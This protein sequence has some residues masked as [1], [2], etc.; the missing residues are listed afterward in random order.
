MHRASCFLGVAKG[1]A[2]CLNGVYTQTTLYLQN[3]TLVFCALHG[4][5]YNKNPRCSKPANFP[6]QIFSPTLKP[7][8]LVSS[9]RSD[10]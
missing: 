10:N 2:T 4:A 1:Q 5:D 8:Y 3:E 7:A 9:K 6:M